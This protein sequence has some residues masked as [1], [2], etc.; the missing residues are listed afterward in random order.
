MRPVDI[1]HIG[2]ELAIKWDDGSESYL[3]LDVMRRACPCAGCQGER[4]VLGHLHKGPA[5]RLDARSFQLRQL[6]PVGGYALQPVWADGHNTGLYTFDYLRD[7]TRPA[8][9]N[10]PE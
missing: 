10:H 7:L 2:E 4:D 9:P 1:Q 3:R 5:Q 6:V 8:P